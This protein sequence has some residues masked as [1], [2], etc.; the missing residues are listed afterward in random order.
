MLSKVQRFRF[1]EGNYDIATGEEQ[2][3][4]GSS[5]GQAVYYDDASAELRYGFAR[6]GEEIQLLVRF[7]QMEVS[8]VLLS[9]SAR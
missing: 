2:L 9:R 8:E 1:G 3:Y 6:A 4:S 7:S 5:W